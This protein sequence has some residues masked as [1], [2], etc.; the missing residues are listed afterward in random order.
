MVR[1]AGFLAEREWENDTIQNQER[2]RIDGGGDAMPE[3][4]RPRAIIYEEEWDY[5]REKVIAI[6]HEINDKE[7]IINRLINDIAEL[8]VL[9]EAKKSRRDMVTNLAVAIISAAS[10]LIVALLL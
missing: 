2:L 6:H 3:D 8:R 5:Y 4:T 7:G 9:V 1:Y 10:A